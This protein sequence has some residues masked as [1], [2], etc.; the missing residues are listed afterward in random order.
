[1]FHGRTSQETLVPVL[2]LPGNG[3]G[4]RLVVSSKIRQ[5]SQA[6][7]SAGSESELVL[8]QQRSGRGAG[9]Y[10]DRAVPLTPQEF[11]VL[12]ALAGLL[13]RARDGSLAEAGARD[14]LE[15]W[16]RDEGEFV[17]SRS[18][19]RMI[20]VSLP[21]ATEDRSVIVRERRYTGRAGQWNETFIDV[22]YGALFELHRS[23]TL[24][25]RQGSF[26][27]ARAGAGDGP[28]TAGGAGAPES[29]AERLVLPFPGL[30]VVGAP[31]SVE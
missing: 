22:C 19:E 30:R 21:A 10:V 13:L 24:M 4:E 28:I 1:M 2:F 27:P 7:A 16:P 3:S 20:T 15:R 8:E 18:S 26:A 31:D 5:V 29:G 25:R 9:W 12:K 23:R 14:S 11:R 6:G 17:V